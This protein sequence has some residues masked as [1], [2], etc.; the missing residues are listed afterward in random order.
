MIIVDDMF[1][2]SKCGSAMRYYDRVKRIVR[3]AY[4]SKSKVYVKRYSCLTC[5]SVCRFLPDNLLPCKHYDKDII[6]GFVLG[7]L[8][9]D[10]LEYE[11]YPCESTIANWKRYF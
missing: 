4:G 2:C 5:G 3:Q 8:N 1:V 10:L 9:S 11:D 6:E 7:L